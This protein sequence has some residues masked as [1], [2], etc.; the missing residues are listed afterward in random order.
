MGVVERKERGLEG[1]EAWSWVGGQ[2]DKL[3]GSLAMK[4]FGKA[5]SYTR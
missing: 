4:I 5:S 1:L 2:I 3:Q